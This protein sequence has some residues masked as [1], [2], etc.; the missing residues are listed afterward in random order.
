MRIEVDKNKFSK[1]LSRVY[2]IVDKRNTSLL[3]NSIL[4]EA[5]ANK[6]TLRATDLEIE[7]IE[8]LEAQCLENGNATLPAALL[9]DIIKRLPNDNKILIEYDAA[10][11]LVHLNSKNLNYNLKSFPA[12]DFPES[13]ISEWEHKFSIET[14][15]LKKMLNRITQ[16]MST[17][18]TRYTLN[19]IE[20]RISDKNLKLA[21]TDGHRLA[22]GT[23]E[24]PQGSENIQNLIIPRK[25]VSELQKMLN[26]NFEDSIHI[27][28]NATKI[29]LN[30]GQ[31]VLRSKLIEG[32]FPDYERVIP[33]EN[34]N[35]LKVDREDFMALVAS[36]SAISSDYGRALIFNLSQDSLDLSMESLDA[37]NAKANLACEYE[38][39]ALELG[40]NA[41]YLLDELTQ[42]TNEDLF[43]FFGSNDDPCII[44][45]GND[46][47]LLY[48][49]MPMRY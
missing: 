45:D 34:N 22:V 43:L 17:E 1:A 23:L 32:R 41:K 47:N 27:K 12:K 4:I 26:E 38:G 49:I 24:A 40:F 28:L 36:V 48:V 7:I 5:N 29:E 35:K 39:E 44:Y 37:D 6:I 3:L 9:H 42:F 18:D 33:T 8:E 13:E 21:A 15:L 19:G 10:K 31:V 16:A 46:K 2:R 20:L 11:Q 14:Q 25:A 30:F